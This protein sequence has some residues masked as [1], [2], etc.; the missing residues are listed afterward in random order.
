MQQRIARVVRYKIVGDRIER[1]PVDNILAQTAE[2]FCADA[3]DLKCMA[4]QMHGMLIAAAAVAKDHPV[5]IHP[6]P[7]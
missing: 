5:T 4:V 2:L 1:H 7:A 3:R 6:Q